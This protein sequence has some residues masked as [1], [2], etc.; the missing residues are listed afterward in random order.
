M[1]PIRPRALLTVAVAFAFV[2]ALTASSAWG[3]IPRPVGF[4]TTLTALEE[5]P[6]I[7][8]NGSGT[9]EATL[10]SPDQLSFRLT[11]S[12]LTS[13]VLF[14][15]IHLAQR[16]VNGAVVIF[17]CGG[18][19]KPACPNSGTVVGT[20]TRADVLAVPAQNIAAGNLADM[21]RAM[22]TGYAY[23]N[24]HTMNFP[25]GEIRGYLKPL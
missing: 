19:G 20:I 12:G 4:T 15:H 1:N 6:S 3:Q 8:A 13:P 25:A 23:A 17:L 9:F 16:P 24:V 11:F 5:V 21:L 18:G 10:I 22:A 7:L 14:A 2:C